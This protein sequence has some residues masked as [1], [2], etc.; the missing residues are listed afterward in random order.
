M[1]TFPPVLSSRRLRAFV[2]MGCLALSFLVPSQAQEVPSEEPTPAQVLESRYGFSK[3]T[4]ETPIQLLLTRAHL[5]AQ[6]ST[7]LEQVEGAQRLGV[8]LE[9]AQRVLAGQLERPGLRRRDRA[10]L[11]RDLA[12][13]L[14]QQVAAHV[15]GGAMG[16][17]AQQLQTQVT[18][19]GVQAERLE[20]AEQVASERLSEEEQ[21][22]A[23]LAKEKAALES[24]RARAIQE[25][26]TR[27]AQENLE[28]IQERQRLARTQQLKEL[29]QEQEDL[30]KKVITLTKEV[31][32]I[33]AALAQDMER[34]RKDFVVRRD[35]IAALLDQ[36]PERLSEAKRQE[37]I[38]PQFMEVRQ[39][40]R[41]DR[42]AYIEALENE[43]PY[44]QAREEAAAQ[45]VR[46][47]T[48]LEEIQQDK[49]LGQTEL[50]QA[51]IDLAQQRLRFRN[52]E[53]KIANLRHE[54]LQEKITL[55]Q[56][57]LRVDNE[58]FETLL[59]LASDQTRSDFYRLTSDQ[60]WRDASQGFNLALHRLENH[61]VMRVTQAIAILSDPFSITLWAWI[62]GVLV[63][64]AV[65]FGLLWYLGR[66][67]PL[68][69]G[70]LTDYLLKTRQLR[71]RP[72]FVV[73]FGEL[74]RYLILP[75][76]R[77]VAITYMLSYLG[78][79]LPELRYAQ[80][81]V[82]AVY[83]FRLTGIVISVLVL[84][85]S[86]RERGTTQEGLDF[87]SRPELSES[88]DVFK[89]E[90]S[91]AKKLV[92]SAKVIIWFT[93]LV[94]YVPEL[95]VAMM[96][97]SVISRIVYLAT[98]W[99][100]VFVVY[101]V[102]STWKEEIARGF[103]RLATDR[104]PRAVQF[105][106]QNKDRP[107]GVLVIA[108]ASVYV[109]GRETARFVKRHV[110]NTQWSQRLSNFLFRK[111]IEYQTRDRA[112]DQEVVDESKL[113]VS[114]EYLALFRQ[115]SLTD[116]SYRVDRPRA[117]LAIL[118][119]YRAWLGSKRQGAVAF[120]GETG[121]G[122]TTELWALT[123]QF[124]QELEG[125]KVVLKCVEL[126]QKMTTKAQALDYLAGLFG[127]DSLPEERDA[128]MKVIL[129]QPPRVLVVDDAHHMFLRQIGGFDALD[130]FLEVVNLSDQKHYWVLTFNKFAWR[131][132]TRVK[133]REHYFGKIVWLE[134]WT[135]EEVEML[136]TMRQ[137]LTGCEA[138]FKDLVVAHAQG[139]EMAFEVVKSSKGYFRLLHEFSK[140]NPRV[141]ITYWL[142]SLKQREGESVIQVGLFK[143]PPKIQVLPDNYWFALNAVAQH[144]ELTA[145]QI[146]E[147]ITVD[148]G[149]CEMALNYFME[150]DVLILDEQ[151]RAKLRA[152]YFRQ[153]LD[154]L[155]IANYLYE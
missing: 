47:K 109:I 94:I 53:F 76:A 124:E 10:A 46:A 91:R 103:E 26:R 64:L 43:G 130:L 2:L 20:Q 63:R 138:N 9:G 144:S 146:A 126:D 22:R 59:G 15:Q 143:K 39:D 108:G 3:E 72:Q 89:I 150:T 134:P 132:L 99:G 5:N 147:I 68:L 73:K 38:D 110:V 131:Y 66:Q 6:R 127:L 148:V 84:P 128:R 67:V 16:L 154:H 75:V 151:G 54:Q 139:E 120:V 104:L 155:T 82:N 77:F 133:R 129:E 153:V 123:R 7:L 149:F 23:Q 49:A 70:R 102:L 45:V 1:P 56:D 25:N 71:E 74:L 61:V 111:K 121:T 114:P 135:Q 69:V 93:L 33:E 87:L 27:E 112:E 36:L 65:I 113:K 8:E 32:E 51:R 57:E 116:E 145:E 40:R 80:W 41:R 42:Q 98:I 137:V 28:Q 37:R 117:R 24:Q 18:L 4:L 152:T 118:E 60:N 30:A 13:T 105:V 115:R 95:L 78:G 106:N 35:K 86:V 12:E 29:L 62:G 83:I 107:W 48:K 21:A 50:G 97:H 55:L 96:G 141:A 101:V 85:R 92:R 11:G 17:S 125:S 81:V 44:K 31:P 88:T 14:A 34:E 140:G 58:T 100:L 122:K 90:V 136:I 79:I 52:L 142:R 19:L 119:H